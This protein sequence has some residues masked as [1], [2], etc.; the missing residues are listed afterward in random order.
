MASQSG[1]SRKP[2][3]SWGTGK[4]INTNGMVKCKYS[5]PEDKKATQN[6]LHM[7]MSIYAPEGKIVEPPS[8][9][10]LGDSPNADA[11]KQLASKA[12]EPCSSAY[13]GT[14]CGIYCK[15]GDDKLQD[16]S[17]TDKK[18]DKKHINMFLVI[19]LIFI[20]TILFMVGVKNK[21]YK[22]YFM[23]TAVILYILTIILVVRK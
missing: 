20:S 22:V 18:N 3:G 10:K 16:T 19:F 6:M 12:C 15:L 4:S 8:S 7:W 11:Y 1:S 5:I 9:L 23:F 14:S 2:V 17:V 13:N 21:K